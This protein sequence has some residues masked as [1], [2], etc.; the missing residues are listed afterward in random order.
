MSQGTDKI[1]HTCDTRVP[2]EATGRSTFNKLLLRAFY[3]LLPMEAAL[4]AH[5]R[6]LCWLILSGRSSMCPQSW[7]SFP[8]PP[9]SLARWLQLLPG[10]SAS[11]LSPGKRRPPARGLEGYF[12]DKGGIERKARRQQALLAGGRCGLSTCVGLGGGIPEPQAWA[13]RES[14]TRQVTLSMVAHTLV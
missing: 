14:L 6:S 7:R 13:P 12:E 5:F 4:Q 10:T 11:V 1:S 3:E 9:S 8:R 2:L